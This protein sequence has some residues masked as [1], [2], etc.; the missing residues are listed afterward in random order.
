[1]KLLYQDLLQNGNPKYREILK[2]ATVFNID[3][4]TEYYYQSKQVSWELESDFPTITPPFEYTFFEYQMPRMGLFDEGLKFL[5]NAGIRYGALIARA[6]VPDS[7]PT[8]WQLYSLLFGP[9]K[10]DDVTVSDFIGGEILSI[11]HYGKFVGMPGHDGEVQYLM[12]NYMTFPTEQVQTWLSMLLHPVYL[13]ISFLHCKNVTIVPKGAGLNTGK[14]SRHAPGVRYHVL[15]IEP[16]KQVL[17]TEGNSETVGLKKAL[18]ICRG[19]FK[20]YR[21][22]GLFGRFHD[23]YW[24][25]SQV[26]GTLENGVVLKD[27]K[28]NQP[29][30]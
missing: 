9:V 12:P 16:M 15:N 13:A 28:I 29:K 24:W 30:N 11:D 6:E 22:T 14:R 10:Y 18:H 2:K 4:V 5:P 1:M 17:K 3:N 26:R 19:H 27:Y 20:D 23:I 7:L 21:E 25:D 8:K